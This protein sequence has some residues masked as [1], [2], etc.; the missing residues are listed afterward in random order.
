MQ[1]GSAAVVT[2]RVHVLTVH[3]GMDIVGVMETVNGDKRAI[4]IYHRLAFLANAL[5]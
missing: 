5:V 3:K 4:K 2:L 1:M